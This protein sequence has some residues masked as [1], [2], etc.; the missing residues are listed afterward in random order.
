VKIPEFSL[1]ATGGRTVSSA[2]LAGQRYVLY[3]YPRANTPGCTTEACEFQEHLPGFARLDVPVIGVSKDKLPALEKFAAKYGLKFPLASDA[4]SD[5]CEQLGV[6]V[7][8]NMYG[9]ASWGIQ[10]STFLVGPDGG[11]LREWRKVKLAGH[12]AEVAAAA[13][14][15]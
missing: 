3:F 1:P 7:E 15:V 5:L 9:H 13:K 4:E 10:R 8:K 2:S 12:V 6:W 14:T 11:I